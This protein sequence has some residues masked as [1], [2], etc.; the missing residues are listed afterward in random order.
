MLEA[1]YVRQGRGPI[2]VGGA[3]LSAG[4]APAW[5]LADAER[6]LWVAANP[7]NEV[8]PF[9]LETPDGMLET[10]S[11]GFGRVFW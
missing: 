5:L 2:S 8:A 11:F 9:R 4:G 3:T 1:P 10:D 6:R 7:S